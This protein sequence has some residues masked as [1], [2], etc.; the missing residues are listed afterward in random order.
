M[1][2]HLQFFVLCFLIFIPSLEAEE[3]VITGCNQEICS[4]VA[5][6]HVGICLWKPEYACYHQYGTC[7]KDT[8]GI[9]NWAQTP[10]LVECLQKLHQEEAGTVVY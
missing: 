6:P 3:C 10:Q 8:S 5:H 9:C 4:E 2:K 7:E 1:L